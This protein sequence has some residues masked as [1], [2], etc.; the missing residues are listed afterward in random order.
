LG[1]KGENMEGKHR[2]ITLGIAVVAIL[3][4]VGAYSATAIADHVSGVSSGA[5]PA[6]VLPDVKG[7]SLPTVLSPS[8]VTNGAH[9]NARYAEL[10]PRDPTGASVQSGASNSLQP[11]YIC[12]SA[13]CP[14]GITDYG[15]SPTGATSG[16]SYAPLVDESYWDS[17]TAL[18]VGIANGGGCLDA[19]AEA[20]ACFTIQQNQVTQATA[21]LGHK[22]EYWVQNV[23]EV[24]YDES[25][26]SP[27]VSGTWSV[28]WLD[29]IWNFSDNKGICPGNKDADPGCINPAEIIGDQAGRCVSTGGAPTFYYCV[30]PTVYDL[31]PPFTVNAWSTMGL[32]GVCQTTSTYTCVNFYGS[33][34]DGISTVFGEYYDAVKFLAGPAGPGTP[35]FLVKNVL[36][37]F[38]LPFDYEWVFG[39]PGGGSSSAVETYGDMQSFYCSSV[40]LCDGDINSYHAIKHAW[41]SGEDTAE[42]ISDV[43]VIPPFNQRDQANL[44][45]ATD[46]PDTAIW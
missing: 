40:T 46:N 5:A 20:G 16:N 44:Y 45:F 43:Y 21:S 25:C 29:N 28:T 4:M 23:P 35:S 18:D 8:V 10:G 36:T 41:S 24:A 22:G 26:S 3:A 7:G 14:M 39:G 12:T 11:S 19:D 38:G 2:G 34:T 31:T 9:I 17:G 6:I 37:A 1:E 15:I 30:G 27:C 33:V 42:S 32:F 13:P